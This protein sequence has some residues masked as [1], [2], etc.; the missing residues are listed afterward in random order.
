[1][2]DS[3]ASPIELLEMYQLFSPEIQLET[4][5]G[6]VKGQ[7][8]ILEYCRGIDAGSSS[9]R[10]SNLLMSFPKHV[11]GET[12][13]A[14]G[15][16]DICATLP[17]PVW[18]EQY[19][20][21]AGKGL[22]TISP[23]EQ[24]EIGISVPE[25]L[26]PYHDIRNRN[27]SNREED[28]TVATALDVCKASALDGILS[29]NAEWLLGTRDDDLEAIDSPPLQ[30]QFKPLDIET[31]TADDAEELLRGLF[32]EDFDTV[33]Q[34]LPDKLTLPPDI[35]PEYRDLFE[36]NP[37]SINISMSWYF[38]V[39]TELQCINKIRAVFNW[40][41]MG[42]VHESDVFQVLAIEFGHD[43]IYFTTN[44]S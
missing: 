7:E 4:P 18:Y 43:N 36:S 34:Q 16:C 26:F 14:E 13:V 44:D 9:V 24:M 20:R 25:I 6:C 2:S 17:V 39:D 35:D 31:M 23:Q 28:L 10:C 32:G 3:C 8:Q 5:W 37:S 42:N 40:V 12:F 22:N 33:V 27:D 21:L 29:L 38:D 41:N 19:C 1:M 30:K 11:K 15:I